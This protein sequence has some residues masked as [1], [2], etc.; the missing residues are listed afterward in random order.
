MGGPSFNVLQNH[1]G[2]GPDLHLY[3]FDLLT[4][5][6]R[7]LTRETL[8]RRRE[9]LRAEVMPLLPDSIRYSET[10]EASPAELIEAVR[11]H[12]FEGI[13]AKRRDSLYEPA[14]RSGAWRRMRVHQKRDLVIGGYI[15]AAETSMRSL[16][17]Y[18][19]GRVDVR[20]ESARGVTPALR[21]SVFKEFHGL[22]TD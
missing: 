22:E 11:E 12:W 20:R 18:Y 17:G 19:E 5:R 10:M 16:V 2:A 9:L 7:D 8:E 15:R 6:G 14:K 21:A 3:A 1:R 13:V 4:L